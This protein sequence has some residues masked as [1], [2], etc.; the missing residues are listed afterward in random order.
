MKMMEY[1][2]DLPASITNH[3]SE[4]VVREC[5]SDLNDPWMSMSLSDVGPKNPNWVSRTTEAAKALSL[6]IGAVYCQLLSIIV[7]LSQVRR[8]SGASFGKSL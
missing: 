8:V 7:N 5:K 2:V 6:L 3:W 1:L 4:S